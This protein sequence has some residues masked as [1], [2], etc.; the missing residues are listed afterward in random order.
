[1][2]FQHGKGTGVAVGK[3]NLTTYLRDVSVSN[4]VEMAETSTFGNT[5]KTFIQGLANT[6]VS[7]S[8][9]WDGGTDASD[10]AFDG[11]ITTDAA[12]PL[13]VAPEGLTAGNVCYAIGAQQ[14]SYEITSPVTDVV[15]LS[16]QF[17]SRLDSGG[18]RGFVLASGAITAT[19]ASTSVDT[20]AAGT[21][22]GAFCLHVTANT[23]NNTCDFIIEESSDNGS[24]DA[25][26]T[27]ATFTQVPSTTTTGEFVL[28]VGV[29]ERYLRLSSTC[30]GT[31]SATVVASASIF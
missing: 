24:G 5:Y 2:A 27:I 15:S 14:S 20:G 10:E 7:M 12:T 1:M 22:R 28:V 4:D 3:Y 26:A 31:G 18:K 19:G 30:A 11:L 16:A 17:S 9:L 29:V 21:N 13:T 6:Q 8:G 23:H 25:W